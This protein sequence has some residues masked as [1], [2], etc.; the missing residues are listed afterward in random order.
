MISAI[1]FATLYGVTKKWRDLE[2]QKLNRKQTGLTAGQEGKSKR[3]NVFGPLG[4]IKWKCVAHMRSTAAYHPSVIQF[5]LI[6]LTLI[7]IKHWYSGMTPSSPDDPHWWTSHWRGLS[8]S[9]Q[10][11]YATFV[12]HSKVMQSS[13][14][15]VVNTLA[16]MHIS[17]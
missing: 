14:E 17:A 7:G 12:Q 1:V 5:P 2:R 4:V 15:K 11:L 13:S 9:Y 8:V 10:D 6:S 3:K 16:P